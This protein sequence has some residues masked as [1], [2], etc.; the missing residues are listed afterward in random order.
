M[1]EADGEVII[2]GEQVIRK[3]VFSGQ[4]VVIF[5]IIVGVRGRGETRR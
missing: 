1:V 3:R 4:R 2:V 5:M